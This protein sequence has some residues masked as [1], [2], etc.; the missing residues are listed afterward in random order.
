M[1]LR[2]AGGHRG[3]TEPAS[4]A[5]GRTPPAARRRC[6][7]R[8][9][10]LAEERVDPRWLTRSISFGSTYGAARSC[11]RDIHSGARRNPVRTEGGWLGLLVCRGNMGPPAAMDDLEDVATDVRLMLQ[12]EARDPIH[13]L[14][15]AVERAGVCLVPIAGLRV[16]TDCPRG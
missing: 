1:P 12:H 2:L 5:P 8:P 4:V 6:P 14:T 9:G 7:G 11:L 10:I 15:A 16:L 3:R 13:N